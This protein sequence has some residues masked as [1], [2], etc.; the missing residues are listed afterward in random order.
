[1]KTN[2][3]LKQYCR[4]SKFLLTFSIVF[5]CIFWIKAQDIG[6]VGND[7]LNLKMINLEYPDSINIGEDIFLRFYLKNEGSRVFERDLSVYF[8]IEDYEPQDY[9]DE[10]DESE[11][12]Q[13]IALQSGDSILVVKQIEVTNAKFSS[14]STN[15]I[16]IWPE[17]SGLRDYPKPE[18]YIVIETYVIDNNNNVVEEDENDVIDENNVVQDGVIQEDDDLVQDDDN[19]VQEDDDKYEGNKSKVINY[20]SENNKI[21]AGFSSIN[22]FIFLRNSQQ[23]AIEKISDDVEVI[24]GDIYSFDGKILQSINKSSNFPIEILYNKS[25]VIVRLNVRYQNHPEKIYTL[26]KIF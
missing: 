16:I 9:D 8:D 3:E 2:F 13:N 26:T 11:G 6:D 25:P 7:I 20:K 17:I 22:N 4:F 1:M 23:T 21:I 12:V 15:V 24:G 5:G 18:S 14:N 10:Y 19:L